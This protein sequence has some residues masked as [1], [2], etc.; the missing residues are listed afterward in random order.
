VTNA[1]KTLIDCV[2]AHVS[3]ELVE[4]AL[5]QAVARALI[6]KD[7]LKAIRARSRAA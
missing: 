3:P 2:D 4:A 5:R 6:D 1:R 7:E